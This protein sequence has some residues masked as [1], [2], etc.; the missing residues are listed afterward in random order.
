MIKNYTF[1]VNKE[2]INKHNII[3][4]KNFIYIGVLT[5]EEITKLTNNI[6]VLHEVITTLN[7]VCIIVI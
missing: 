5:N 7:G 2:F 3:I 6:K 4:N 1:I